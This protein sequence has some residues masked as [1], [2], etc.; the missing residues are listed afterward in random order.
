MNRFAGQM[1]EGGGALVVLQ[2][3]TQVRERL[4]QIVT[5]GIL[6]SLRPQETCQRVTSLRVLRFQGQIGQERAHL[7]IFELGHRLMVEFGLK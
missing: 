2:Q 3:T 4:P 5:R 6:R 1:K 7:V